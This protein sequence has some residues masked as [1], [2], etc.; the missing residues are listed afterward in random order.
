MPLITLGLGFAVLFITPLLIVLLFSLGFGFLLGILLAAAYLL[1][2]VLGGMTGVV[3]LSDVTLR[4]LFK[5]ETAG[6]GV[7]VLTLIGAFILLALVQIIPLIGS[8]VVVLLTVMGI[9]ALKYQFWQRYQA[10]TS[11]S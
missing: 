3:Y 4:R 10:S 1:M 5:K 7:M 2:L 8:L 6:K 11:T 9:G